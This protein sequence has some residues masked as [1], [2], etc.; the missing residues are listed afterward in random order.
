MYQSIM[1]ATD[2]SDIADNAA[3]QAID[4]AKGLGSKLTAVTVTEPYQAIAFTDTMAVV[5]QSDY[6]KQCEAHAKG[7]LTKVSDMAQAS[8]ISCDTVHQANHWPY[9]GVIAA[10]EEGNVDLIVVGS[11]GRRGLESLLLGSQA[12]KLLSHTKIPTLVV[13]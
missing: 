5:N 7:I 3:R 12:V 8:G 13:R 11:H 6:E 1:I 2:G 10:A 4:L 9:A